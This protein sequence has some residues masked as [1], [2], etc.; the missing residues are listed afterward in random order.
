MPG[1]II[2]NKLF[3]Q[4]CLQE[5]TPHEPPSYSPKARVRTFSKTHDAKIQRRKLNSS[6]QLLQMLQNTQL[7]GSHTESEGSL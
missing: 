2:S 3:A 4:N 7:L 5:E 6:R 1:R